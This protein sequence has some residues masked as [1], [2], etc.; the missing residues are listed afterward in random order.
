MNEF[1]L[2]SEIMKPVETF[3][4]DGVSYDLYANLGR[5]CGCCYSIYRRDETNPV[6]H[7]MT[8]YEVFNQLAQLLNPLGEV[9]T[10]PA[11]SHI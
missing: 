5:P 2:A 1:P 4:I 6:Q 9:P 3:L 7:N 8:A 11:P 10:H